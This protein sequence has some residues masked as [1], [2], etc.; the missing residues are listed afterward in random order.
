MRKIVSLVVA[1]AL[2]AGLSA[3]VP[4]NAKTSAPPAVTL[5]AFVRA[6]LPDAPK[7]FPSMRAAKYD[8]DTYYVEYTVHPKAAMEPCSKCKI[9][10][11]YARGRY[12]ENWYLQDGWTS[13]WTV[14]RIESYVKTQLGP[15][16][17]GFS[18]HRTVKYSY[19]TLVWSGPHN[20]WVYADFYGKGF[21]LRVGHDLPKAVHVLLPPSKA[22]L[23]DLR[24]ASAN[25]VRLAVPAGSDNFSTLRASATKKNIFGS[26]DYGVTA[27]FGSMFRPC[28]ISNIANGFGYKT[29]NR[30]GP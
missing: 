5:R 28:T 14:P 29:F 10:D 2:A 27:S 3:A 19:P 11:Q 9:Y 23:A 26:N 17:S 7:N 15:L 4:A 20:T 21:T 13:T 6:M 25:I 12:K 18:L 16:L 8:S 22:Q 1:V 24:S 30:S